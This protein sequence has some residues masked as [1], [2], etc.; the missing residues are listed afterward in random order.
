MNKQEE[1]PSEGLEEINAAFASKGYSKSSRGTSAAL[2]LKDFFG[3]G[4]GGAAELEGE[5]FH[6]RNLNRDTH[7]N[8]NAWNRLQVHTNT[9]VV[10]LLSCQNYTR[11]ET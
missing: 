2:P 3:A 10:V 7:H 5:I 11:G 1:G 6:C 4:G 9:S 8:L